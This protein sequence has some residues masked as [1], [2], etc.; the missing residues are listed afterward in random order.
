[1]TQYP[2]WMKPS[3]VLRLQE[4]AKTIKGIA[5]P[6]QVWE[7]NS[8]VYD[9]QVSEQVVHASSE[10]YKYK[11]DISGYKGFRHPEQYQLDVSQEAA[12]KNHANWSDEPPLVPGLYIA[13]YIKEPW[14]YPK[15][16][17]KYFDGK[18]WY[19]DGGFERPLSDDYQ[20]RMRC[21]RQ[22]TKLEFSTLFTLIK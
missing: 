13:T 12:F 2:K 9:E 19:Y 6:Q 17:I 3:L 11:I 22:V 8:G 10:I 20:E 16:F 18:V 21:Y 14:S 5:T 1:M 7:F 4:D 15:G